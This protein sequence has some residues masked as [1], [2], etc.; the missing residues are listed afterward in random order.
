MLKMKTRNLETSQLTDVIKLMEKN[1]RIYPRVYGKPVDT[2]VVHARV[3]DSGRNVLNCD[4]EKKVKAFRVLSYEVPDTEVGLQAVAMSCGYG[5]LSCADA[6]EAHLEEHPKLKLTITQKG[7]V[8]F[9]E[10]VIVLSPRMS[11]YCGVWGGVDNSHIYDVEID[12]LEEDDVIVRDGLYYDVYLLRTNL[13]D[14]GIL[15]QSSSSGAFIWAEKKG[16]VW[17][18]SLQLPIAEDGRI[19]GRGYESAF[20]GGF[21]YYRDKA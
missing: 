19:C 2:G 4:V 3:M 1:G 6:H 18:V 11:G 12:P 15:I 20:R 5:M 16:H 14:G 17:V 8:R 21:Y 7:K 9:G 13:W 10:P